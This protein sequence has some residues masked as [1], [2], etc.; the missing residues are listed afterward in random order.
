MQA[1]DAAAIEAD[2]RALPGAYTPALRILRKGWSEKLAD[3]SAGEVIAIAQALAAVRPQ[4]T[5]WIAYELIRFHRGAYDVVNQAQLERFAQDLASWYAVDAFGTTLLGPLWAKG[6]VEDGLID[7]WT[8]SPNRWL[9]RSAL[10]ATVGLN[11]RAHGAKGDA[12]RTLKICRALAADRDDM[13][14]KALS[15]ALRFLSHRDKAAVA[16]FMDEMDGRLPARVR[17]EVASKLTTG[18]KTVRAS[19]R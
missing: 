10:V 2:I 7:A 19:E 1:L 12:A 8:R 3:V 14:E 15:W 16:G 13:V 17:R 11:A 9:R 6:R 4:Q 18:K 5:K